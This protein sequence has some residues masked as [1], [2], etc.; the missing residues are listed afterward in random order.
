MRKPG[1]VRRCRNF[2]FDALDNGFIIDAVQHVTIQPA[3]SFA[4]A[5][6]K[7]R[8]VIAEYLHEY[9]KSQMGSSDRSVRCFVDGDVSTA[10][11]GVC[12]FTGQVLSTRSTRNRWLSVP[13][14]TTLCRVRG[15][16]LPSLWRFSRPAAG[17]FELRFHRFFQS[18]R[19]TGD[20]VI[21][22]P[23]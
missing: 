9:R 5:S 23:P 21:N 16:L 13:P 22:G 12:F 15:T 6:L 1:N 11:S 7:P 17:S 18:N 4:S 2:T 19:F 20:Y 3:S 10:Q 14:E 8:R